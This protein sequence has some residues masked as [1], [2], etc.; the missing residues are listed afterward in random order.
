MRIITLGS[1]AGVG[2]GDDHL[3]EGNGYLLRFSIE[4]AD[5]FFAKQLPFIVDS[6]GIDVRQIM[7]L[8]LIGDGRSGLHHARLCI[9]FEAEPEERAI[10]KLCAALSTPPSDPCTL[11]H[12]ELRK[13]LIQF[14]LLAPNAVKAR[15][16]KDSART[17]QRD[18]VEPKR[19]RYEDHVAGFLYR[20]A[21]SAGSPPSIAEWRNTLLYCSERL[22]RDFLPE[23]L[24]R[25]TFTPIPNSDGSYKV[26]AE[27]LLPTRAQVYG[28]RS[29]LRFRSRP[30]KTVSSMQVGKFQTGRP[31][32]QLEEP[33]KR[34][35][36]EF[37]GLDTR[38]R[39]RLWNK[40]LSGFFR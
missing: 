37:D 15:F 32:H 21:F 26:E 20:V 39:L 16:L 14:L 27:L 11:D 40:H 34:A 17:I 28:A 22:R 13:R 9:S 24:E 18:D 33:E 2:E 31:E 5:Q 7:R 4:S 1:I 35:L 25:V 38:E 23:R 12:D 19:V 30:T 10:D 29:E 8:E 36:L 3:Y 6:L